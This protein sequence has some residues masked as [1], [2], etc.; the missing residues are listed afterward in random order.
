ME[1]LWQGLLSNWLSSLLAAAFILGVGAMMTYLKKKEWR[2]S[3]PLLYGLGASAFVAVILIALVVIIRMP[4]EPERI[5]PDN[6][7]IHARTWLEKFGFSV[8]KDPI[9]NTVFALVAKD[10]ND[11]PY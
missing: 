9:P 1:W 5:T 10:R 11:T 7:E 4:K 3:T 8:R 6:V 2:L